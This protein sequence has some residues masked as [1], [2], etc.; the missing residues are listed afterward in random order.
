L[1]TSQAVRLCWTAMARVRTRELVASRIAARREFA[2]QLPRTLRTMMLTRTPITTSTM[3]ISINVNPAA[4]AVDRCRRQVA[5]RG[6]WDTIMQN[7]FCLNSYVMTPVQCTI[8]STYNTLPCHIA[9]R[10]LAALG[11]ATLIPLWTYDE[12]DDAVHHAAG[13]A[14]RPPSSITPL[15]NF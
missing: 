3:V 13:T 1:R 6:P 12:G 14:I 8:H 10:A 11:H 4:R 9:I 2:T 7:S 15:S 5:L